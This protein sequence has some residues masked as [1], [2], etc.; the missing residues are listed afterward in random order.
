MFACCIIIQMIDGLDELRLNI[1]SVLLGQ[2]LE[3]STQ[4]KRKIDK[5]VNILEEK[6][7]VR[8]HE[9]EQT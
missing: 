2:T 8:F 5:N 4:K 3:R 7:I 6:I 1:Y 9:I